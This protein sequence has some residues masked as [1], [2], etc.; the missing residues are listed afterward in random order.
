MVHGLDDGYNTSTTTLNHVLLKGNR[1]Y[2]HNVFCVNYTTYDVRRNQDIFN[3]NSS[4]CD[5]MMLLASG[6]TE[7]AEQHHFCYAHIVGAYHA[8]VQYI[9]PGLN[10]YKT[11][12]LDFLHV[13]W[14]EQI[15]PELQRRVELDILRFVPINDKDAFGFID[16][17][18]I[19]RGCHLI[20]TF[21]KGRP[22]S[23]RA[24]PS[25]IARDRN[26]W[27]YYYVNR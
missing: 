21:A 5:I 15:P 6:D 8:N 23:D 11:R 7:E 22:Q 27:K 13:R 3:P 12:R 2:Q 16:P 9:G 20:P 4:H 17:A 18:E 14:F 24:V 26:D 10:D 19:L 25:P 1:I